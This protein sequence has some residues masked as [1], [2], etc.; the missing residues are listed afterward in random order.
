MEYSDMNKLVIPEISQQDIRDNNYPDDFFKQALAFKFANEKERR[1]YRQM[2]TTL[3][4]HGGPIP[5]GGDSEY[6]LRGRRM[7]TAIIGSYRPSHDD[8]ETVCA[9]ILRCIAD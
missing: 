1:K 7:F 8:K 9:A 4:F 6:A 3:F 2:A 5:S